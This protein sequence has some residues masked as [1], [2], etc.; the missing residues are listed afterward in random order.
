MIESILQQ[1]TVEGFNVKLPPTQL[2]R[3][4]YVKVADKLKKIGGK[5]TGGRVQ[6]FVFPHDPT[7]LLA[8]IAGGAS[9]NLKKEF[10][11][12]ATPTA[13]ARRLVA[14]ACINEGD[15][16]LE[17]SAG[18]GAIVREIPCAVDCFEI[19]PLM[20]AKLEAMPNA[21]LLGDD[22]L[23]ADPDAETFEWLQYDRIVANPPF[24]KNQDIDHIR[25]MF[26][27]LKPGGRMV[28]VASTHWAISNSRREREFREWLESECADTL[29]VE[30]GTF[31][32][33]GTSVAAVIV[34]IDKSTK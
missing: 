3:D 11:F 28:S 21:S 1:C 4:T 24:T 26:K 10:Q 9:R 34:V 16:V 31:K 33:S 18:D 25:H 32:E 23:A 19:N 2:D 13:L 14:L 6:A 27:C 5:W 17:P 29:T 7:G 8:E 22:F 15:S 12:F 20:H 30:A